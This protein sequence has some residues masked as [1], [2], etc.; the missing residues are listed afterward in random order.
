MYKYVYVYSRRSGDQN[1][2]I[3]F[4]AA[5]LP[6]AVVISDLT[7]LTRYLDVIGAVKL[8]FETLSVCFASSWL[9]W[10]IMSRR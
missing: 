9:C 10:P 2:H 3:L 4:S 5:V 1:L 6:I 8:V 7:I